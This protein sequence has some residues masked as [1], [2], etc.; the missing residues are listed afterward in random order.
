[1]LKGVPKLR[2]ENLV[3]TSMNSSA[4]RYLLTQFFTNDYSVRIEACHLPAVV[5]TVE[6]ALR[7]V[8]YSELED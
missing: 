4:E 3:A 6:S 7:L 5:N 2:T 1:M 8:I